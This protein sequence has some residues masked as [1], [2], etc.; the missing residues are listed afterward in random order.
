MAT[1]LRISGNYNESL[2]AYNKT[3]AL[4]PENANAWNGK[5][6]VLAGL[7]RYNESIVYFDN[8]SKINPHEAGVLVQ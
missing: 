2:K 3:I 4:S 8:A 1:A 7:E 5:G 6:L